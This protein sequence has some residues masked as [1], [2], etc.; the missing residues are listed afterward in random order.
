MARMVW[1]S[2]FAV[3]VVF[4]LVG[5]P[6]KPEPSAPDAGPVDAGPPPPPDFRL[7]VRYES[8]DG[9]MVAI[10]FDGGTR[11]LIEPTQKLAVDANLGLK[12][13]RVRLFDEADRAVVSDDEVR[14]GPGLD[15]W[16]QLPGPLKTGYRYTL[17]V[18]AET[19]DAMQDS[20]GRTQP[21]RRL[22]FQ[23]AGEKQKPVGAPKP[24]SRPGKRRH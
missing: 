10:D 13:Y 3:A 2:A 15:Y 8:G 9:G 24:P 11:P 1:R 12:N 16:I 14:D 19:G 23:V 5:C 18:D 21:D 22:E 7:E 4:L 6:K 20:A 17:V